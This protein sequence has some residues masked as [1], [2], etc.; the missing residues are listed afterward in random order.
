M[1]CF[2]TDNIVNHSISI[3]EYLKGVEHSDQYGFDPKSFELSRKI[4]HKYNDISRSIAKDF[5]VYLHEK[6]QAETKNIY[7]K[8]FNRSLLN[9]L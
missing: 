9:A 7:E 4:K 2:S 6:Y 8:N 1:G 5:E 3:R